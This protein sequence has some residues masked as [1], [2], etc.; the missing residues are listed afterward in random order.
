MKFYLNGNPIDSI[1]AAQVVSAC[2]ED[3]GYDPANIAEAWD[4]KE[5]SEESR[6]FLNEVSGFELEFVTEE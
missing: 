2:C 3:K 1:T 4:K 6:E 5:S